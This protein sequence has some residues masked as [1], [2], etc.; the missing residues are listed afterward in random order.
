MVTWFKRQK[1]IE[2]PRL[3]PRGEAVPTTRVDL[4]EL[5]PE[6]VPFFGQAAYFELGVFQSL[7]RAVSN[8]PSLASKEN[9]AS[10]AGVALARHKGLVAEIGRHGG[11][12]TDAMAPFTAALDEFRHTTAG[13]DWV[14]L[15]LG[16]YLTAG[17]LEDFFRSLSDGLPADARHRA[18]QI[19]DEGS[20]DTVLVAELTAC[21]AADPAVASRLAMWGR[22]LVGDTL[23]I[24]R[25]ALHVSGDLAAIDSR[26]EPVFTELIAAHTRR[27]DGL[28]LTA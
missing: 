26:I 16:S 4:G 28:G 3:K 21:L 25:S 14:E 22:R 13:S 5:T 17:L 9:L 8:A 20:M 15:L 24:A 19:L 2:I 27:M 6:L 7:S 12:A 11:D 23:L 1:R 18:M 10:A